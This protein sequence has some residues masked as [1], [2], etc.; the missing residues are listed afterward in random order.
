[1]TSEALK[2]ELHHIQTELE[3]LY[4]QSFVRGSMLAPVV[5]RF[6]ELGQRIDQ[7]G[8]QTLEEAEEAL[9]V[10]KFVADSIEAVKYDSGY[11]AH[12]SE[13]PADVE[14]EDP[15]VFLAPKPAE[16]RRSRGF[17]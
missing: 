7:E 10:D 5:R 6:E 15:S 4:R 12:P 1:M 9:D 8:V 13:V 16:K 14:E 11:V 3:K 17:A 2:R